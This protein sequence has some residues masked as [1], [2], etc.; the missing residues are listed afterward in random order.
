[1]LLQASAACT[2]S[3]IN[4]GSSLNSNYSGSAKCILRRWKKRH[5]CLQNHHECLPPTLKC[6]V[7]DPL[8]WTGLG[9]W[10]VRTTPQCGPAWDIALSLLTSGS[11]SLVSW[12][13]D[14]L[15]HLGTP[16]WQVNLQLTL[17]EAQR[18][19]V[20]TDFLQ[21]GLQEFL[22]WGSWMLICKKNEIPAIQ[23]I[24]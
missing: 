14:N 23:D 19:W 18:H 13:Q 15:K 22:V 3:S 12:R 1:M 21:T 9:D 17:S 10:K 8:Q 7:T 5:V 11:D 20:L 4:V 2:S 24:P 6:G 16:G